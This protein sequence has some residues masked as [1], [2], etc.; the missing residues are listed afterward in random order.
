MSREVDIRGAGERF[1]DEPMRAALSHWR[2][3]KRY[4]MSLNRWR[5]LILVSRTGVVAVA[6]VGC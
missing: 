1:P 2:H 5:P 6:C 3:P 4:A